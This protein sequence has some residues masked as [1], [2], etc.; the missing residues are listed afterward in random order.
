MTASEDEKITVVT[1]IKAVSG[2]IK[3]NSIPRETASAYLGN[4]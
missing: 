3:L 1:I 4:I 2:R